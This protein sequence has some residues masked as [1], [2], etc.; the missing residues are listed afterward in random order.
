MIDLGNTGEEKI[1]LLLADGNEDAFRHIFSHY[2]GRIYQVALGYLRSEALAEEVV[3]DVFMRVWL[4]RAGL[5]QVHHFEGW[6]FILS[7]NLILNYLEKLANER[8]AIHSLSRSLPQS[9]DA[10]DHRMAGR[11]YEDLLRE[12]VYS[13]SPMQRD[14]YRM[15]REE[16]LS[17]DQIGQKLGIS[18]L[19]VKTH[20]SRALRH[21][22]HF[23][24]L[25]GET[26][27]LFLTFLFP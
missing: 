21:I 18:A 23:F 6:L 11:Q 22:R 15:A 4:R 24:R 8:K 1:L 20:M 17:Y 19:T 9:E 2:S 3:Q 16:Q 14:V 26:I 13:L 27:R 7:K 12:A 5:R 25:H 10:A